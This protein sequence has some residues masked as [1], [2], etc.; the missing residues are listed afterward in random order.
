MRTC[1]AMALGAALLV[2]GCQ[3]ASVNTP[4]TA[5]S[6]APDDGSESVLAEPS[7]SS[8]TVS[9]LSKA[10][11]YKQLTAGAVS[12]EACLEPGN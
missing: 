9:G 10:E 5:A 1:L 7:A 2:G 4:P 3:T 12:E 11:C 6:V 8:Q